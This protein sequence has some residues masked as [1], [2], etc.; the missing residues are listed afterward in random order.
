METATLNDETLRLF[1]NAT[2]KDGESVLKIELGTI[3]YG[4]GL[5]NWLSYQ[6]ENAY[7]FST[8][9]EMNAYEIE[10]GKEI[11]SV[12]RSLWGFIDKVE[13]KGNELHISTIVPEGDGHAVKVIN[14]KDG[15]LIKEYKTN[16]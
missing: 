9:S 11:W 10:T 2:T 16:K 12:D 13:E 4:I 8:N 3:P 5:E 7:Y 1:I 15:S 6:G 14:T